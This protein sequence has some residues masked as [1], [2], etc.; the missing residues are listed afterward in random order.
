MFEFDPV[1]L[2]TVGEVVSSK[3]FVIFNSNRAVVL[4]KL[5]NLDRYT[6]VGDYIYKDLLLDRSIFY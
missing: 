1:K 3:H 6:N 5:F 2:D 4:L